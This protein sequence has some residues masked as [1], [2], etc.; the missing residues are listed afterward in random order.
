MLRS[1]FALV[2]CGKVLLFEIIKLLGSSPT[3]EEIVFLFVPCFLLVVDLAQCVSPSDIDIVQVV[4]AVS[5]VL[6]G[7]LILERNVFQIHIRK[8]RILLVHDFDLFVTQAVL[9]ELSRRGDTSWAYQ[10]RLFLKGSV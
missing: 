9:K 10:A 4:L 8:D 3:E 5:L 6:H 2:L 1:K 7:S